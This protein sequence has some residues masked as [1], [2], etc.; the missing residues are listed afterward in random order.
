MTTRRE[1]LS[2]SIAGATGALFAPRLSS[3][4]PKSMS[5]LHESS[6]IKSFDD[7]FVKQLAP[8][9]E[10]QTG[11]KINYEPV[12]VGALLT[13]LTT[14]VE[15]KSGP[16]I[17]ATGLNWP[18][19]FDPSLVDVTDIATETGKNLGGWYETVIDAVGV[20]KRWKAVDWGQIGQQGVKR[21]RGS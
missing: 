1:F 13:R 12:S 15:T 11:I 4:A 8:A 16:E 10:K 17:S 14:V 2:V 6:F 9:Y 3:A 21:R 20:N 18:W 5:V 19:L 7:F